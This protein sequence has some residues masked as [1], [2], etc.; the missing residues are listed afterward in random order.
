MPHYLDINT[1]AFTVINYPMSYIEFFGVLF[2]LACVI[3]VARKKV[4]TWP[5]GIVGSVMFIVLFWQIALYSDAILNGYFVITG[6]MGWWMWSKKP[7]PL[8]IDTK[9]EYK[10][11]DGGHLILG[12]LVTAIASVLWGSFMKHANGF[13]PNIFTAPAGYPMWDGAILMA[14]FMAQWLM[15][16]KRTECWVYW[17]VIDVASIT[18][19][20][21]KDIRFTSILYMGFLGLA[22]YGLTRWHK[23]SK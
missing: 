2:N 15:M 11:S 10:Y 19:F 5:I 16:K 20:W 1:I 9:P 8:K 4:I 6:F 18:L 7:D 23:N 14:S 17:I 21:V 13:L 22:T 12:V 3:L